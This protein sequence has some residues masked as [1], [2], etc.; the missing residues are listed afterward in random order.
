MPAP[1]L[2][3]STSTS[4]LSAHFAATGTLLAYR[5]PADLD[6]D[7]LAARLQAMA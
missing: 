7:A 3:T 5:I 4:E 2:T 1:T 6:R